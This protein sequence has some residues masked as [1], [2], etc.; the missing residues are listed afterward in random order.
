MGGDTG[1]GTA[2]LPL[3][4]PASDLHVEFVHEAPCASDVT[5]SISNVRVGC[6]SGCVDSTG[7]PVDLTQGTPIGCSHST[8]THLADEFS[9]LHLADGG[10]GQCSR[11]LDLSSIVDSFPSFVFD[12]TFDNPA[13]CP[14]AWLSLSLDGS[15]SP[16]PCTESFLRMGSDTGTG[17]AS[18]TIAGPSNSLHVEFVHPGAC[19]QP[20]TYSLTNVRL[21]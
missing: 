4:A 9:A 19:A 1:S 5:Y 16:T 3:P 7:V 11:S 17:T 6:I 15:C 2:T 14:A 12:W 21:E 13:S 18:L 10:S 20:V 8:E